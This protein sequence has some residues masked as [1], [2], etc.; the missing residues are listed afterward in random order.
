[1]V[2]VAVAVRLRITFMEEKVEG[3]VEVP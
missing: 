3:V 1:L 2:E